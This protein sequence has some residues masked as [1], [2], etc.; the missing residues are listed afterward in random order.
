M[1][2]AAIRRES[3]TLVLV[4][5]LFAV[6]PRSLLCSGVIYDSLLVTFVF[7]LLGDTCLWRFLT[8]VM[9]FAQRLGTLCVLMSNIGLIESR[10]KKV[11][12]QR[13]LHTELVMIYKLFLPL[14]VNDCHKIFI[15]DCC[16]VVMLSM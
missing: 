10:R 9:C 11:L 15:T 16:G 8:W 13:V 5:L 4:Y 2:N 7:R 1:R 12:S 3:R 14:P 6:S